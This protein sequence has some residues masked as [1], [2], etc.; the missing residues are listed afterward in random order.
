MMILNGF[1]P[2]LGRAIARVRPKGKNDIKKTLYD[3]VRNSDPSGG[4]QA[5]AAI[6]LKFED[7]SSLHSSRSLLRQGISFPNV[8]F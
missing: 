8:N 2:N 5:E 7:I 3:E 4:I 1:D 6:P